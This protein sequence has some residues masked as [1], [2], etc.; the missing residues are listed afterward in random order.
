LRPGPRLPARLPQDRRAFRRRR[1][2]GRG[3]R[4]ATG[5]VKHAFATPTL[6][7][8]TDMKLFYTQACMSSDLGTFAPWFAPRDAATGCDGPRRRAPCATRPRLGRG[9]F[10]GTVRV[11]LIEGGPVAGYRPP[12]PAGRIAVVAPQAGA[13]AS[14]A[15]QART[16][17]RLAPGRRSSAG[18]DG[19]H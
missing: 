19:A 6:K 15:L 17:S 7:P 1:P 5:G 8:E 2:L 16:A 12:S 9:R 10:H 18:R 4:P 13:I 3:V 11:P 14:A